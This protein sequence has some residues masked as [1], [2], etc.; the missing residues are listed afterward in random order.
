MGV[1]ERRAWAQ[2]VRGQMDARLPDV[3][4]IVI[5]HKYRENLMDYLHTRAAIVEVP[6]EGLGIGQQLAWLTKAIAE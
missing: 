3:K 4:R 6:L 5:W 1:A 2:T